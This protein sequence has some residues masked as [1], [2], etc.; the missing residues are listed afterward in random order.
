MTD[1]INVAKYEL[2][3][4]TDY[5]RSLYQP[6]A[7]NID[8][9]EVNHRFAFKTEKASW[10][11]NLLINMP[12]QTKSDTI[13]YEPDRA[14]DYLINTCLKVKLPAIKVKDDF[15]DI[16]KICWPHNVGLNIVKS[17]SLNSDEKTV[18]SFDDIWL[19]ID[20]HFFIPHARRDRYNIM[21]GNVPFLEEWS[22]FLPEYPL[23]IPQPWTYSR[24]ISDALPLF[25][26]KE[27]KITHSYKFRLKLSELLRMKFYDSAKKEWREIRYDFKYLEGVSTEDQLPVPD[28]WG[29]HAL[30]TD[31]ERETLRK[32]AEEK[33][34]KTFIDDII[35]VNSEKV[36]SEGEPVT[37][38]FLT[39]LP[40]R[41][42]FFVAENILATRN[43]NYSN[44]TTNASD[45]YK[46]WGPITSVKTFSGGVERNAE[47]DS[48]FFDRCIPWYN[49]PSSFSPG[50][51][52][53]YYCDLW[54][55]ENSYYLTDV[56]L[57]PEQVR[58]KMTFQLGNTDPF[59]KKVAIKRYDQVKDDDILPDELKEEL[60]VNNAINKY[61]VRAR[62]QVIKKLK[63]NGK[64]CQIITSKK[65]KT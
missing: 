45:L 57:V 44:F 23:T 19:N 48:D 54:G 28:L 4:L 31:D 25:L 52:A 62:I 13:V 32:D 12:Y 55:Y 22:G 24:T 30:M 59:L 1:P 18:Q 40:S 7:K 56:T 63:F 14:F 43:R 34:Y 65:K 61:Y 46:G 36:A 64:Q 3:S 49:L 38:E 5:Q 42:I 60:N 53:G 15:K 21:I 51:D 11:S 26:C 6:S 41:G 8:K 39:S 27:S 9:E 50:P 35:P 29:R 16:V 10:S 47:L 2:N 58:I 17:A 37:L 33:P 20:G